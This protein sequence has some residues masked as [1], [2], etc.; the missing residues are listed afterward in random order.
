VRGA[1]ALLCAEAVVP[2]VRSWLRLGALEPEAITA[3]VRVLEYIGASDL[4][5]VARSRAQ[6]ILEQWEASNQW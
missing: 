3:L 4:D 2:L 1:A 6:L 5:A